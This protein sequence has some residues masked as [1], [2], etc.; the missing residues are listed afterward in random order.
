MVTAPTRNGAGSKGAKAGP[1]ALLLVEAAVAVT[2]PLP[3]VASP[4][5]VPPAFWDPLPKSP[6][7]VPA[8][9]FMYATAADGIAGRA[10]LVMFQSLDLGGQV[11][12]VLVDEY[13]PS[14]VG[15][16]LAAKT[17]WRLV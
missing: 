15:T 4:V 13:P 2:A 14:P 8:P 10:S 11:L 9:V 6:T 5:E 7:P 17:F 1:A 16:G 3:A 12:A